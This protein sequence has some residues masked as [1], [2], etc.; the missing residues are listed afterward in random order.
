MFR[1]LV[2]KAH[3][4]ILQPL[5]VKSGVATEVK[6]KLMHEGTRDFTKN[7]NHMYKQK[8]RSMGT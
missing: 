4:S 1:L 2:V 3:K 5:S 6:N 8:N 7:Q